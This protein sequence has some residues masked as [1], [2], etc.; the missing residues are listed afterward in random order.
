MMVSVSTI[1]CP[2]SGQ[3]QQPQQI[4]GATASN[5]VQAEKLRWQARRAYM[6]SDWHRLRECVLSIVRLQPGLNV[7]ER[8]YLAVSQD[9]ICQSLL[10]SYTDLCA[11]DKRN[12]DGGA[13]FLEKD[14]NHAYRVEVANELKKMCQDLLGL[15]LTTLLPYSL[16]MEARVDFL[17]IKASQHVFLGLVSKADEEF[18]WARLSFTSAWRKA[19][20]LSATSVSRLT[21]ARSL[22]EFLLTHRKRPDLALSV[23]LEALRSYDNSLK[24]L[25]I[26]LPEPLHPV[27]TH[28]VMCMR[29]DAERWATARDQRRLS[30]SSLRSVVRSL[31]RRRAKRASAS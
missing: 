15:L 23:T 19:Q 24:I 29:H 20:A 9:S 4:P 31:S 25:N 17:R 18:E 30:L 8:F 27:S 22:S 13:V 28:L 6:A 2:R 21:T 1:V 3:R 5:A 12:A 14:L 26:Y 16:D 10:D 11:F 7:E